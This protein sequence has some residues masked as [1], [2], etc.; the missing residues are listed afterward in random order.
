MANSSRLAKLW[1]SLKR[2]LQQCVLPERSETLAPPPPASHGAPTP[3]VTVQA[4]RR[5]PEG[6]GTFQVSIP[7]RNLGR[8]PGI[9]QPVSLASLERA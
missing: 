4:Y 5:T 6:L 1:N 7:L 3:S 2:K 9:Q 8:F